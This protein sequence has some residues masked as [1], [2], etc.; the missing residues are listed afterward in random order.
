MLRLTLCEVCMQR[1]PAEEAA[2]Q[3][4]FWLRP[5]QKLLINE[6]DD[7]FTS[8]P[9]QLPS[10]LDSTVVMAQPRQL[11]R[12]PVKCGGALKLEP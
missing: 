2:G 8:L 9:R 10:Q 12:S 5:S 4:L 1:T 7:D 3:M 6:A 11:P